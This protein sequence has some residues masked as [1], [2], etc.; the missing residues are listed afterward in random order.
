MRNIIVFP[1]GSLPN[2]K[3]YLCD[4]GYGLIKFETDRFGLRNRDKKWNNTLN[5]SNIFLIGD[6]FV[7]GSCVNDENTMA[8]FIEGLT[9][10]NTINLGMTDN[11]PYEYMAVMKSIVKPILKSFKNNK[12]IIAFYSNDSMNFDKKETTL[13]LQNQ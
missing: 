11:G 4:E 6:S 13:S 2:T 3:S 9:N 1:I 7:H 8:E 12:V 5:K 10:T